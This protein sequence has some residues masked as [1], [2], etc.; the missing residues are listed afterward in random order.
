MVEAD[1]SRTKK[2]DR[3]ESTEDPWQRPIGVFRARMTT[4]LMVA[5]CGVV[6]LAGGIWLLIEMGATGPGPWVLP[7]SV[8]VLGLAYFMGRSSYLI[9][10]GGIVRVRFGYRL[11]CRWEELSEIRDVQ[12]KQGLVSSRR[13]DLV[14]KNGSRIEL[15]N[16]GIS[17]FAAMIDLIRQQAQSQG[18][19]WK[20]D[21]Q[22][23]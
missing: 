6:L 20:E 3:V 8:V 19:P 16:L 1:V 22:A 12:I 15:T 10:P 18:I 23:V 11:R 4:R 17:E 9:Y 13:C 2:E 7:F 14:K 21:P 5:A